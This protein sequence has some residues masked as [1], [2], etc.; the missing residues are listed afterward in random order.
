MFFR[1]FVMVLLSVL[2]VL[3]VAVIGDNTSAICIETVCGLL[4]SQDFFTSFSMLIMTLME[5]TKIPLLNHFKLVS[6]KD[7]CFTA[8]V[9]N[10]T[11][12]LK[13]AKAI[14]VFY[15]SAIVRNVIF[16]LVSLCMCIVLHRELNGSED[17]SVILGYLLVGTLVVFQLALHCR[18]LYIL[19]LVKNPLMYYIKLADNV[20]KL[21]QHRDLLVTILSIVNI[22][23]YKGT[24]V[25]FG[26]K[27]FKL[28][29]HRAVIH[30][31]SIS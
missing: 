18:Q 9:F 30:Y 12:L 19:R 5:T 11:Y 15:I 26:I 27:I 22:L 13:S 28:L 6:I 2:S 8:G 10:K 25:C 21:K 4:L 24:S 31:A 1:I 3:L 7:T 29:L 17:A 16:I 23:F 20:M 14:A